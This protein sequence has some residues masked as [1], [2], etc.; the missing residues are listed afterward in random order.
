MREAAKT[1]PISFSRRRLWRQATPAHNVTAHPNVIKVNAIKSI[2]TVNNEINSWNSHTIMVLYCS[3]AIMCP[4]N[5]STGY[6]TVF[7]A[8]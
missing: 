8:F 2:T 7:V 3:D 5:A 6:T 4:C 1:L